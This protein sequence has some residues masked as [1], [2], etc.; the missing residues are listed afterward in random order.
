MILYER[1]LIT[2]S[3]YIV[4]ILVYKLNN[5]TTVLI[6]FDIKFE[7]LS[8]FYCDVILLLSTFYSSKPM[9]LQFT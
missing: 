1:S 5:F 9:S 8:Y 6:Y 4:F 3:K 2:N 7:R